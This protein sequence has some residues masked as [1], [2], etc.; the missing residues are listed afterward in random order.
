MTDPVDLQL[1]FTVNTLCLAEASLRKP[2]AAIFE[3]VQSD[4]GAELRTL[5]ALVAAGRVHLEPMARAAEVTGYRF[6]LDPYYDENRA[7]QLI[8]KHGIAVVAEQV[9]TALR[10]FITKVAG[11]A[12]VE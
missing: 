12:D 8:E 6:P 5:R 7:G 9:G 4:D 1:R 3:E 11:T 2:L 10:E